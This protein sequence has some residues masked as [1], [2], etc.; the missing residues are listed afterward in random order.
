MSLI[1][2]KINASIIPL[3]QKTEVDEQKILFVG[4]MTASG[5]ATAGELNTSI[6]NENGQDTLFGAT[7]M[8][9]TMIR[10]AKKL[11]KVSRMD[12]IALDDEGASVASTGTVV[13]T[14]PASAAGSITVSVGS[15]INNSYELDLVSTDTETVIGDALVAAITAD[16]KAVVTAVNAAGTVTLTAV[17]KGLEGDSI[18]IKISGSVAGVGASATAMGSGAT[19]PTLTNVF[20]VVKDIRYETIIWPASYT[21]SIVQTFLDNRYNSPIRVLDGVA[22]QS[23]TDTLANLKLLP[24]NSKSVTIHGNQLVDTTVHRGGAILEL[25]YVI[26]SQIGAIRALRLTDGS[27]ISDFVD[28][29]IGAKDAFGGIHT[30]SLPYFNTPFTNLPVIANVDEWTDSERDELNAAGLFILGNNIAKN[31]IISDRIYSNYLTNPA[32]DPDITFKFLNYIDTFSVIRW[33]FHQNL[34]IRFRQ[35]RLTTG[36]KIPGYN[37]ASEGVIQTAVMEYYKDL[38]DL[39]L[40]VQSE[41]TRKAFLN[42]LNISIDLKDSKAIINMVV[43]PVTQLSEIDMTIQISFSTTS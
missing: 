18:G 12:A 31:L 29:G 38:T 28:V 7:S 20:D 32:G 21:L 26:A 34:E 36:N 1:N 6:N 3:Y 11:N 33:Y 5:T 17:N 13:F 30:A 4:Q 23:A 25:D 2:P 27:Q 42:N 35:S 14:G 41:D 10:A 24:N 8:L 39:A 16:T 19:N 9:A 22:I 43:E 15:S 40:I 37:I